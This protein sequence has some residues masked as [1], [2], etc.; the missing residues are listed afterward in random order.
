MACHDAI[1]GGHRWR[2]E[3]FVQGAS[4]NARTLAVLSQLIMIA[5]ADGKPSGFVI[6]INGVLTRA[7]TDKAS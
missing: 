6:E 1:I 3:I 4:E 7:R 2:L 5:V